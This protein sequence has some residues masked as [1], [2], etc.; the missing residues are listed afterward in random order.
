MRG[1]AVVLAVSAVLLAFGCAPLSK[2]E[3]WNLFSRDAF[4]MPERTLAAIPVAAGAR[5]ADLGAGK[6]YFTWPLSHAVGE[7]GVVWAVEVEDDLVETLRRGVEARKLSNV[8]VVRA[9]YDDSRLPD[10]RV[11]VVLLSTVYHHIESR[12]AYMTRLRR[13][14][15]P[16]GRVAIV[17][18]RPGWE[19]WLILLPPG[20][21][22]GVD[23]IRQEMDA[24]G[25]RL[26]G[27]HDFLPAHSFEVFEAR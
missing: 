20:H 16:G 23:T 3:G 13:V 8:L 7:T 12:V 27:S 10:G 4:S 22:V 1:T 18:P 11:D 15:A 26:A 14:L 5:V 2:L 21:G 19:S 24:A 25:Y 6:G 17:E 9:E